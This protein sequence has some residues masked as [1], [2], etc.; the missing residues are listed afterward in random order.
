MK[1]EA[2]YQDNNARENNGIGYSVYNGKLYV[3][4]RGGFGLEDLADFCK[5]VRERCKRDLVIGF[6]EG[7]QIRDGGIAGILLFVRDGEYRVEL[8][9]NSRDVAASLGMNNYTIKNGKL[10]WSKRLC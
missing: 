6:E 8:W 7:A 1:L 3:V 9:N 5:E 10:V 4:I 2:V